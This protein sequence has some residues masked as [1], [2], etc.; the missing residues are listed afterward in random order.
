[1]SSMAELDLK[2][3]NL[4]LD[5]N[6]ADQTNQNSSDSIERILRETSA[7]AEA[8][9]NTQDLVLSHDDDIEHDAWIQNINKNISSNE[10]VSCKDKNVVIDLLSPSPLKPSNTSK[11]HSS[12]DQ[13]I[14][15][16][17]LSDSENEMSIEHKQKA[18]ELRLF[19]ASIRNENH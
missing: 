18:K 19:L 16:I 3:Q 7:M 4:L 9:L 12:S 8:V 11:F 17:N 6:L 10:D 14:E 5:D 15:V 13:H 2:L 1:M